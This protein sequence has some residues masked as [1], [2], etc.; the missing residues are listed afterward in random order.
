MAI[1]FVNASQ[2]QSFALAFR[3]LGAEPSTSIVRPV[4]PVPCLPLYNKLRAAVLSYS[5]LKLVDLFAQYRHIKG[6]TSNTYSDM[7]YT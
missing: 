4:I 3:G 2:P 1:Q 5:L 6:L 7:I